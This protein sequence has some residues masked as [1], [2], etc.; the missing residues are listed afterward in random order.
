M[1]NRLDLVVKKTTHGMLS[2]RYLG[3]VYSID[4]KMEIAVVQGQETL[5]ISAAEDWSLA[6]SA[7]AI[8]VLSEPNPKHTK[9]LPALVEDKH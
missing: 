7:G 8:I 5:Y 6:Y 3:S 4:G 9:V 1:F 2:G